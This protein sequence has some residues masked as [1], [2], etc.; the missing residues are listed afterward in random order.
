[1]KHTFQC[2]KTTAL[3]ETA[4]GRVKGY[5]FDGVLVFKGIP[6]ARAR[7]FHMPE[8][9]APW[10]GVFDAGS[11]GYVCPLLRYDR[12]NGE[13]FVPHRYW[14][15][16]EDCLNLN[17]WTPAA[18]GGKRP[19]LVWLHGGGF[20]AGSS[21]E[22]V[23]YDGANMAR[24]GDAVVVSVNHRLNILGY[25]DLSDYG[26]EYENSGNAGG[27]D[28]I[29]ALRWVRENIAA[30]GGD[31]DN[32][33]VFGQS[34]GGAKVTALLQ[35]PAADGLYARGIVMSGV[36]GPVL[37]DAEGSGRPMAEALMAELGLSGVKELENADFH[38]LA[39]AYN[40]LKPALV[41]AG[42]NTGCA[43]FKNA[44][45]FGDP[46]ANG[47][48][49]ET[50]HV[51]LLVG[52]V[53]GEANGFIPSPCDRAEMDEAAQIAALREVLGREGAET[54]LP[55]FRAAYPERAPLDILKLDFMFRGPEIPYIKARSALNDATWSYMFNMDQPIHGGS[56][57]WHCSDIPYVFHNLD[58][59]EYPHGP[60]ADP[61]L[62]GRMQEAIFQTVMAF[63]R[64]GSP[65]NAL[66]P[67]WP[68]SAPG[69]ERS[70]L[71]GADT[72]LAEN[73]DHALIAAQ[74]RYMGPVLR[75]MQEALAENMQ[76]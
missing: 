18:D 73:F 50:A 37:A 15:T 36:I 70:L 40:K 28:I 23:A 21:I 57:P 54:I 2:D 4:R 25:F 33:T 41:K 55:L 47:F 3:V 31:P 12:P 35:S 17:L 11:Y 20:E 32:V 26:P 22:H 13:L 58:L 68:A 46:V 7:R 9:V 43:P 44:H 61:G 27:E 5:A 59:V 56:V 53:F 69:A 42:R 34:G 51:P 39:K 24:L 49:P 71:F 67:A 63:A 48:R 1:M 16:D 30:F 52:S 45:Y 76:H 62:A 72:H 75:R 66:I 8:P 29:A 38:L 14:P 10:E 19:V 60:A 65:E 74:E 6:Y 64:S